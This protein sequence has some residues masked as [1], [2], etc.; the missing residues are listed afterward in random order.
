MRKVVTCIQENALHQGGRA[1]GH[2]DQEDC[3]PPPGV[4]RTSLNT[5]RLWVRATASVF[6]CV[7]NK[8]EILA[9]VMPLVASMK[10]YSV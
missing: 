4:G 3:H 2:V 7:P 5:K 6:L 1:R 9:K 8:E 10:R